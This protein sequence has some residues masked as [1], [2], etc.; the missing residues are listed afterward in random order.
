MQVSMQDIANKLGLSQSTVSLALNNSPK[1]S[2]KTKDKVNATADE[3]GYHRNPYVSALMSARRHGKN[4]KEPPVIAV[5]TAGKTS[6]EWRARYN[7]KR[8][9]E[10]CAF[11]AESL[12]IRLE[13][14][15]VGEESMTARRLNDI[16]YN[17]G[18]EGAMLLPVGP[19][20]EKLNHAWKNLATVSYG[21]YQLEPLTDWVTSD[22][23]GNMEKTR[24]IIREQGFKR[25]GFAMDRPYVYARDNRW[26]AAYMMAYHKDGLARLEPWL[27][28]A[29]AFDGFKAWFEMERP[30]VIICVHA[31]TVIQWLEKIGLSVPDDV[32]VVSIGA[33]EE[34]GEVTGIV[35]EAHTCGK[36]AI[37]MLLDRVYQG[38]LA[39]LEDPR[40]ITVAGFWNRGATLRYQT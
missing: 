38:Q 12:G 35:E 24:G 39:P 9:V 22:Y 14:F 11:A 34:G 1:I 25:I 6:D 13:H 17:R 27:D 40:H 26:R 5:V 31:P 3:M 8:F 32:G 4:P 21:I 16:F 10:G 30:D 36:M 18:I 7:H 15:W 2:Q 20:R 29:P 28:P 33:A 37:E 23:Y 19:Y